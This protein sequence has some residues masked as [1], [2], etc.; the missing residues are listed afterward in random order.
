MGNCCKQDA[1]SSAEPKH[2]RVAY[3]QDPL[4]DLVPP[5]ITDVTDKYRKFELT[6]PFKRI[7]VNNFFVKVK[8]AEQAAGGQGFVT[9]ES[10]REEL[11]SRAWKDLDDEQSTLSKFLLSPAFKKKGQAKD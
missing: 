9:L 7:Q 2:A 10:L 8:I 1:E 11:K 6:L 5:K 4:A 3:L